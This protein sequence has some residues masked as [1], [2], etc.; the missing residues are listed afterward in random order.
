[1]ADTTEKAAILPTL[2]VDLNVDAPVLFVDGATG[3]GTSGDGLVR[4]NLYHDL[5]TTQPDNSQSSPINRRVA[6]R[7]IMTVKTARELQ[8]WLSKYLTSLDQSAPGSGAQ[9][10]SEDV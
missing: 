6:A 5:L 10:G 2:K 4:F 8:I 9:A 7:L 3:I 1:M